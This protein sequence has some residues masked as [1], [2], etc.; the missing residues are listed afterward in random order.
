MYLP[1]G[2]SVAW[3]AVA[4]A[5]LV[6]VLG[7]FVRLSNAGLSCPDWPTCYGKITWPEHHEISAANEAFPER[8]VETHKAWR[9]QVH[10]ILAVGM[11]LSTFGLT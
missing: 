10:R 3:F 5:L 11:I 2:K 6:I 4:F 7:A 1:T 9:E 8:P